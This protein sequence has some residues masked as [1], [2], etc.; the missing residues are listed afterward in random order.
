MPRLSLSMIVRDEEPHLSRALETARLYADEIVVVDTGSADG[1]LELARRLADKVDLFAWEDDFALARNRSLDL[2]TGDFVMFLDAD[3]VVSEASARALREL[4]DRPVEWDI[5]RVPYESALDPKGGVS[6]TQRVWRNF[7]GIRWRFPI[8]ELIE[9]PPGTRLGTVLDGPR[10]LHWPLRVEERRADKHARNRRI[11]RR[12]L[13]SEEHR[14]SVHLM[15]HLAKELRLGDPVESEE[16][17]GL[18]GRCLSL[19]P[20]RGTHFRS[21]LH[22]LTARFQ[23]GLGHDDEALA[24]LGGA[25]A[26]DPHWREPFRLMSDLLRDRRRFRGASQLL[27]LASAIP[28]PDG[29]VDRAELYGVDWNRHLSVCLEE[30]GELD[31]ALEEV[32]AALRQ[33]P[34]DDALLEREAELG[35]ARLLRDHPPRLVKVEVATRTL[36]RG[37]QFEATFTLRSERPSTLGL[38]LSLRHLASAAVL[39]DPARDVVRPFPAGESTVTRAFQLPP[40]AP[41]GE[42]DLDAALRATKDGRLGRGLD[43]LTLVRPLRVGE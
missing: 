18:L 25:I 11:L 36:A 12:A 2:C 15:F 8:H 6:L 27:R 3:D 42:Y 21:R 33:A 5:L 16:A 43:A 19:N 30:A 1:T 13:A 29:H 32:R 17:M 10:V 39:S 35:E 26:E 14:D 20:A 38:G 4:V 23:R 22:L 7:A 40:D 34:D 9:G 28:R 41:E 31:A 24:S 37:D